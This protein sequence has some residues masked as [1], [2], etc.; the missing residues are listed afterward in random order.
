MLLTILK[1][2]GI[3]LLVIL[4][5]II[6]ILLLILLAPIRYRFAGEYFEK[7]DVTATVK[8]FPVALKA[9]VSYRE[10]KLE[11]TVRMFGGVILT[12]TNAKL[13]WLGRRIASG[14]SKEDDNVAENDSITSNDSIAENDS[15]NNSESNTGNAMFAENNDMADNEADAKGHDKEQAKGPDKKTKKAGRRPIT[16]IISEKIKDLK[17]KVIGLK[18]KLSTINKKKND[19]IKVYNS[20]RFEKAKKDVISYIKALFKAIK[21]KRLEGRVHFG[22]DDPATT[23]EILGGLSLL[24]PLY[25]DHITILPDFDKQVIEGIL[26]GY[27]S[28][29]LWSIVKIALKAFFNKNL[30]KV[31]KKFKTIIEA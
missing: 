24:L 26:K 28:I 23:G 2:I 31:S 3:I 14:M 22:M 13:S 7:P 9:F 17:K 16:D 4:L 8:Y 10:N 6:L 19:L 27:G 5:V 1:V 12:N 21:P 30:V 29:R 25:D 11:Y 20:K 18:E 15:I